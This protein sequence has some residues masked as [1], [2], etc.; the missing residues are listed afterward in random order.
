MEY[1]PDLCEDEEYLDYSYDY[2][3]EEEVEVTGIVD[4][5]QMVVRY[6][7]G[8]CCG[9]K[10]I[11][12]FWS[13][14]EAYLDT[15]DKYEPA[16]RVP[17]SPHDRF[18]SG[19]KEEDRHLFD[20]RGYPITSVDRF[21]WGPRPREKAVDRLKAYLEYLSRERPSGMV[22]CYLVDSQVRSWDETLKSL[23]FSVVNR[24]ENS[25][26]G[27]FISCYQLCYGQPEQAESK[28]T[29]PPFVTY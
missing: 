26:S 25:N 10:T 12:G 3:E 9:V 22:D 11:E 16:E 15:L 19:M 8:H 27:F 28:N 18:N 17:G 7:A 13:S 23:G 5:R 29:P 6:H 20:K 2:E 1:I 21:Y 4:V 24:W 14:P